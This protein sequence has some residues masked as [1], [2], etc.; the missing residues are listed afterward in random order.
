MNTKKVWFVTGT[1]KGLGLALVKKLLSNG[2]RVAATSRNLA[3]LEKEIGHPS[4]SFLPLAVNVV[5]NE[6]AKTAIEQCV[7]HFGRIDVVVNNAGYGLIGTLE[8]VTPA[9]AYE[10]YAVNVFGPLNIIRNVAPYLR[11]Q[12]SGHIINIS[13]V[14][15]YSGGFAGF[16]IYCSTKFAMAGFTEGLAA[17]MKDF[18]VHVTVVYPGYFRTNFLHEGSIR[19]AAAPI[20]AYES[21]RAA[22]TTHLTTIN[23]HQ[24]NDPERA[25]EVLIAL[26]ELSKPPVHLFLGKD[27]YAIANEKSNHIRQTMAEYEH[28]ATSTTFASTPAPEMQR[29]VG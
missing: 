23:G 24:P 5:D 21:A 27:A 18:G 15:G 4:D 1:S 12:Q 19:R 26:S 25:A 16:G 22:E 6:D 9:E 2:Y 7:S 10:N 11:G 8:E 20:A 29:Q 14:G 3:S 13:S 28:L 17:E